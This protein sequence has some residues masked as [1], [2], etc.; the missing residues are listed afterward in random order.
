MT[1]ILAIRTN[2]SLFK[3]VV[4]VESESSCSQFISPA[5]SEDDHVLPDFE[6]WTKG[7]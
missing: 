6:K 5:V 4:H 3:E 2:V 7:I 1:Y